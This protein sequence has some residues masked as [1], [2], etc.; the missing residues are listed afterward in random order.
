MVVVGGVCASGQGTLSAPVGT[1]GVKKIIDCAVKLTPVERSVGLDGVK[2]II[3]CAV[4]LTL[5]LG[6]V[7]CRHVPSWPMVAL[8]ATH[9]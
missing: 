1:D 9:H 8:I 5:V 3:D 4:K 6:L 2:K 7:P